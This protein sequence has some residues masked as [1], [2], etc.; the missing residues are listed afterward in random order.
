MR[1]NSNTQAEG[2]DPRGAF[3]PAE[4]DRA[5]DRKALGLTAAFIGACLLFVLGAIVAT[6]WGHP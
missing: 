6:H 1:F 5:A 2:C 4:L 3:S